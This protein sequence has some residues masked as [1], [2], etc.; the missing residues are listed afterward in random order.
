M[1]KGQCMK[2]AFEQNAQAWAQEQFGTCELGDV[3]RTTRLVQ[4]AERQAARPGASTNAVCRGD[5]AIAEATYR[6]LRNKAIEP[7]AV[8][9]GPFRATAQ[10]CNGREVLLAI[11]DTTTLVYSH[12]VADELGSVGEVSGH[13]VGGVLVHSVLMV[14]P[15][16]REPVGL[17]D[18][19]TW[20]RAREGTNRK[21]K[22]QRSNDPK[23]SIK[24]EHA[25]ERMCE[26][27]GATAA[28]V[29]TV[30]DREADTYE[31][32]AYMLDHR[33]RL[34]IRA[35]Q[36]RRLNTETARLF[37]V[38]AKEPVIG[39]RTIDIS[40]RG[41][42][43]GRGGQSKRESRPARTVTMLMR[44]RSVGLVRPTTRQ[45]G[46]ELLQLNVVYLQEHAPKGEQP[47]EWLLLTTEPIADQKQVERVIEYYEC[48]WIIEEFHKAWKSGVRIEN[49]RLQSFENLERL[50][51]MT[52][53]IAVRILQLRAIAT[54]KPSALCEAVLSSIHWQCLFAK[55]N[56]G[57][58]LPK[59]SPPL[60]WALAAI[61]KLGGW[62]DTKQTG[63]IGWD[64]LWRGWTQ[65]DS[66]V[67]GFN[68]ARKFA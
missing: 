8:A 27:L 51:A 31:Y 44:A 15:A 10:A 26:R 6:W 41:A 63:R 11:Q 65:L 39:R 59:K 1:L 22:R 60:S 67:E 19:G 36:D 20:S 49:R 25:T 30:C 40:Q 32:L 61:A 56:P 52:A 14:D 50:I 18:Q 68:F 21:P 57:K 24:W 34:V 58:S 28:N 42:Q 4:Y 62:R 66:I 48:R 35:C 38:M 37:D 3:R 64:A 53:P 23:E 12:N 47:I 16:H 13:R 29:I 45:D 2:R 43:R 33:L 46:P 9:E 55:L 7:K 54:A 17:I 5:D